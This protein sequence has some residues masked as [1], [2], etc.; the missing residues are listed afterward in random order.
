MPIMRDRSLDFFP[1]YIRLSCLERGLAIILSRFFLSP[2]SSSSSSIIIRYNLIDDD[3]RLSPEAKV[4]RHYY[5]SVSCLKRRD[6]AGCTW[7]GKD[8][9]F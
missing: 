2:F 7:D 3:L 8:Y 1:V 4:Q 9:P 5:I 6:R